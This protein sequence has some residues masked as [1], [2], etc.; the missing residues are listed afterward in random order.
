MDNIIKEL[1]EYL[2]V[3]QAFDKDSAQDGNV[4]NAYSL[5]LASFMARANFLM[6][7]Y[8]KKFRDQKKAA[9]LTLMAS[10][11]ATQKYFAPSL[12]KD[13]VDS[14]CSEVGHVYDLA[15]RVSRTCV[16]TL[17]AIKSITM[18]LMSERK[19]NNAA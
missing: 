7:D 6:A 9:Y 13:F 1:T 3:M 16:H 19:F 8:G 11:H 4:L 14:Q 18:N 12:A 2:E 15:E 17:E 5:Q 10:T